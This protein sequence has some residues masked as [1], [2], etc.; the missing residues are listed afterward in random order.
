[1]DKSYGIHHKMIRALLACMEDL[2]LA[3]A[4]IHPP[5]FCI[6]FVP[7]DD[8]TE[9][10][11]IFHWWC[12]EVEESKEHLKSES[13]GMKIAASIRC[14]L[15][16]TLRVLSSVWHSLR[17]PS[18][19]YIA[20]V[21]LN[22]TWA[23]FLLDFPVIL[24]FIHLTV[25]VTWYFFYLFIYIS[26]EKRRRR[27]WLLWVMNPILLLFLS[28]MHMVKVEYDGDRCVCLD[29]AQTYPCE[30]SKNMRWQ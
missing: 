5:F 11:F 2:L 10:R 22:V 15:V 25:S 26:W 27:R 16:K 14:K 24:F 9:Q 21:T 23:P 29:E 19:K 6:F 30:V 17:V 1:M 12:F 28:L 18:N 4:H 8:I 7:F 3:L 20:S 13:D